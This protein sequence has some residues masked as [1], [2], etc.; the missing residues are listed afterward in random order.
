[1]ALIEIGLRVS[2]RPGELARVAR[3]LAHE[4]INL[5][6]ISVDSSGKTGY[7]RLIVSRP[8]R[9]VT[10]LTAAGHTVET[11]E[12]IAVHLSDEAGSFLRVLDLLAEAKV[13][14]T[15]V[16]ILVGREGSQSLIALSTSD[17]RR[18]RRVLQK[19]KVLSDSVEQ[20]I[21]NADLVAYAPRIPSES[22]G[23]MM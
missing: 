7:V 20:I 5:A 12:L 16:A 18:A 23:L 2:N 11:R 3:S 19:A 22:V 1:M 8:A 9:A 6:A 15:S 21:S 4:K 13:N 17:V 10:L 14:V